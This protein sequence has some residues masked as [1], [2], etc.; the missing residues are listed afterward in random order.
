MRLVSFEG[1]FGRVEDDKVVPMGPSLVDWLTYG[2]QGIATGTPRPLSEVRLLAPVPRPG[3]I[4]CVGL[5]YRDHAKE[6]GKAV[7]T[8]PVLFSKFANSVIGPGADVVVPPEAEKVD[9]EAELAVVIGRRARRVGAADALD[10]VA[11]YACANDVSSRSLQYLSDQWMLGKA[12]DTFLPLGP[13][14]VTADEVPDPQ[15]LGIRCLVNDELLQDSNTGQMV[16]GVAELISYAS[17]TIT[18]EPGDLLATGTPSG[19]GDAADPPR[20]LRPGDRMR[21]EIDGLGQLDNTVRAG[22]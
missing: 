22:S 20:Y 9:Y 11:G 13:Y 8:E 17:R 4:I 19:V 18:L 16:F 2:T 1:G 15:A 14:L 21:V 7:P 3:K 6:T 5:N 10:H 12:I